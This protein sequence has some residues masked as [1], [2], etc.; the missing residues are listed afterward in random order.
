MRLSELSQEVALLGFNATVEEGDLLLNSVNRALRELYNSRTIINKVVLAASG[1]KPIFYVKEIHRP[2]GNIITL[3]VDGKAFSMRVHGV[4]T[5]MTT[6]GGVNNARTV[7]SPNEATLVRGFFTKGGY[8]SLWAD[9]SFTVYDF[10]VFKEIFSGEVKDI[11]HYGPTVTFDLRDIYGD[12]MSFISPAKDRNGRVIKNC[13]LYDGKV[14]VDSDYRGEINLS[15]RRLPTKID[16]LHSENE[17]P[18]IDI[19]EEYTHIFPL[20]VASYVWLEA[21]EPKAKYY[22][23]LYDESLE[24]IDS[25]GYDEI[26]CRYV[27]T[28]G[29]A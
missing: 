17:D 28:N 2:G 8:I 3:P 24:Q 4:M 26:D 14:E 19:P 25:C 5:Y 9:L 6:D 11:P 1:T 7:I 23:K 20:L 22:K 18:I 10:C 27:D 29:W 21:D 12:F 16:K 15:Y 13:V